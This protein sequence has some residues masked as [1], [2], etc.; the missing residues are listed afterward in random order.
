MYFT[1]VLIAKLQGHASHPYL[2]IENMLSKHWHVRAYFQLAGFG[3]N[4]Q[5]GAYHALV[6]LEKEPLLRNIV[7]RFF[8]DLIAELKLNVSAEFLVCS[9]FHMCI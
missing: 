2:S 4:P 3:V 6:L 8:T 9:I 5:S 1:F 7:D